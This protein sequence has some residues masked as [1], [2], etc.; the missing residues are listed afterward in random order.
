VPLRLA[1]RVRLLDR[2]AAP[3]QIAVANGAVKIE[4][5]VLDVLE[6][7][8]VERALVDLLDDRRP[9]GRDERCDVAEWIQQAIDAVPDAVPDGQRCQRGEH[10]VGSGTEAIDR[11]RLA[12]SGVAPLDVEQRTRD[13]DDAEHYARRV[14]SGA[15]HLAS[16]PAQTAPD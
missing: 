1:R 9:R 15:R 7:L 3:L 10:E 14:P 2:A 12:G 4:D 8:E 5:A 13:V 6:D 11:A 16:R